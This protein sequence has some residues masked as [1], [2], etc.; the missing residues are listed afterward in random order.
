MPYLK[1]PHCLIILRIAIALIFFSHALVRLL[2][3]TIIR[4][5]E[6]LNLKGFMYG[7]SFVW[8]LTAFELIGAVLLA[9]GKYTKPIS[10]GFIIILLCGIILIHFSLGWFVGEHG[11]GGM[12][13]SFI[14]IVCLIT[15]RKS[16]V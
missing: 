1:L 6:Y 11:T 16:V 4:F 14:L 2:N 7:I 8:V 12:E 10:L 15:D 13:Y 5:G 9:F 3:D